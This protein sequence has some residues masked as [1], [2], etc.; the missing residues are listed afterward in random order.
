MYLKSLCEV[1]SEKSSTMDQGEEA[2]YKGAHGLKIWRHL[3]E[4]WNFQEEKWEFLF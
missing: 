2:V 3:K 4:S 1:I